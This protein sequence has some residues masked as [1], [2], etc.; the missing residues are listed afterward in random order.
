[1]SNREASTTSP[2]GIIREVPLPDIK[3]R[4]PI[5]HLFLMESS[6]SCTITISHQ[7]RQI[8]GEEITGEESTEHNVKHN[9]V[10]TSTLNKCCKDGNAQIHSQLLEKHCLHQDSIHAQEIIQRFVRLPIQP[11]VREQKMNAGIQ[12]TST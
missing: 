11:I 9:Q 1:M 10:A 12:S 5:D 3:P 8:Q 2:A 7:D 4:S 6:D